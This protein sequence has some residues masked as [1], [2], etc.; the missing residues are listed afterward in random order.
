MLGLEKYLPKIIW[1]IAPKSKI[2]VAISGGFDPLHCGHVRYIQDSARLGGRLTVILNSDDFL[3]KKKGYVFMDYEERKEMLLSIR[4]VDEVFKCIDLDSSVC[5]TLT[6]LMPDIF[7]KGGDRVLQNI[8]EAKIC[9]ELGIKMVFGVGG[10]DKPSSS[11]WLVEKAA[12]HFVKNIEL[13]RGSR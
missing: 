3:I 6:V 7:A 4:G 5:K 9:K 13:R 11:S 8:P 2:H 12:R 1:P 10:S